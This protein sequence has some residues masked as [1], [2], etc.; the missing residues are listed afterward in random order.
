MAWSFKRVET[1]YCGV[2]KCFPANNMAVIKVF[3][4]DLAY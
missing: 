3:Q 4:V 1:N 2:K